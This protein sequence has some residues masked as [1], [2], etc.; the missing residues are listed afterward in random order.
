LELLQVPIQDMIWLMLHYISI[1][2]HQV[3]Q[4]VMEYQH[5]G[6]G[7]LVEVLGLAIIKP[8]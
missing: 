4:V 5:I 6:I 1:I 2:F 8:E 3:S 7:R